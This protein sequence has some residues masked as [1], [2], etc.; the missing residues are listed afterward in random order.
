M[1]CFLTSNASDIEVY[2]KIVSEVTDAITKAFIDDTAYSGPTPQ[3]LK[4]I[5]HE[6]TIL[7]K[8]GLGWEE[9]LAKLKEKILPNLLRTPSTD[10][11]AH[12]HGP[13]LIETIAAE[14][15]ISTFNQSMD[16]W[17]PRGCC[18]PSCR[19]LS[20]TSRWRGSHTALCPRPCGPLSC[21]CS[22]CIPS[23]P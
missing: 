16:S 7:P 15:I 1:N 5:I 2:K 6:D 18:A 9:V 21:P 4:E 20:P 8:D 22:K 19:R 17:D 3:E 11:M 10:Y 13:S 12:L 23:G 14:A